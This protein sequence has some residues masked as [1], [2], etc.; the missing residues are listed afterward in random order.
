MKA[1]TNT[2]SLLHAIQ[3]W[4]FM[5]RGKTI[6]LADGIGID[7]WYVKITT[8]KN[9]LAA[10]DHS[11]TCVFDKNSGIDKF[12]SEYTFISEKTYGEEKLYK[13]KK[14]PF[15]LLIEK[16][17]QRYCLFVPD[18]N[19]LKNILFKSEPIYKKNMKEKYLSDETFRQ[20]FDYA[21]QISIKQRLINGL[22]KLKMNESII[23]TEEVQ[24]TSEVLEEVLQEQNVEQQ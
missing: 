4:L 1:A 15:P 5:S 2:F 6:T 11:V 14:L 21:V 18:I 17:G 7:G 3:Q 24:E 10:S 19:N 16:D 9:K 22:F 20:W 23:D 8:A 13:D 12:W